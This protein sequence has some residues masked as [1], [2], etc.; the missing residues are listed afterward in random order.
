MKRCLVVFIAGLML[1]SCNQ[2]KEIMYEHIPVDKDVTTETVELYNRLFK[3]MDKGIMVGH[4]DALAYGHSWYKESGRSDVKD[5]AGDYPAV[6]GWEL[7]HVEI[8]GAEFNLDS[9]YFSDMKQY[10]KETYKRG[11]G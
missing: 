10:I 1:I 3:L 9:V 8:G 11:G 6:V 5:V 2:K 7:G 4:Q